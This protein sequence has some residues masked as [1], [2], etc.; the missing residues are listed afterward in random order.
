M[1]FDEITSLTY[2][3]LIETIGAEN[4]YDK[5]EQYYEND[6]YR[7]RYQL[8]TVP[9]QYGEIKKI[10]G[11]SFCVITCRNPMRYTFGEKL[12]KEAAAK[13]TQDLR[14]INK[15]KEVT[16]E[17][18]RN[19]FNVKRTTTFVA[20]SDETTANQ[21]K[22]FNFDNVFQQEIFD[23]NFGESIKKELGL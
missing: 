17:P 4:I 11:R 6:E 8:E 19:S 12:S 9:F 1:D 14:D 20:V 18:A 3:K 21:W 16:F 13:K 7:L 5:I 15:T 22:F 2:P 23:S 10:E